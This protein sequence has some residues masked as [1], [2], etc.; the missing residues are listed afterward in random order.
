M[1]TLFTMLFALVAASAASATP[2]PCDTFAAHGTP[3]V[4]AHSVVRALYESYD[5]PLYMVVRTEDRNALNV[6]TL[7]AGGYADGAAQRA[8][9]ENAAAP[10]PAPASSLPWAPGPCCRD[11]NPKAC[12][13]NCDRKS[14]GACPELPGPDGACVG[15][16]M[17]GKI[18]R[19]PQLAACMM[20]KIYDQSG[21][22]NDLHVIG[23]PEGLSPI[24]SGGRLYKV[25]L[26]PLPWCWWC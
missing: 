6:S 16:A 21:N 8:F 20:T 15:C 7:G 3:C 25:R 1:A 22:R 18:T 24:G 11:V 14:P 4:A 2:L 26:V 9:C 5:G 19:A 10:A 13:N 23:Q 17:C 12:P